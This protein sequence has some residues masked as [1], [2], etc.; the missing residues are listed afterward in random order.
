MA[1]VYLSSVVVVPQQLLLVRVLV[2]VMVA[3]NG[4]VRVL[5]KP[6]FGC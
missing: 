1:A 6:Y 5:W 3:V 2:V 4:C